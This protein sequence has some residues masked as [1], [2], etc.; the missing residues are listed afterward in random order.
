MVFPWLA[1][2]LKFIHKGSGV[3]RLTLRPQIHIPTHAASVL[4]LVARVKGLLV[5]LGCRLFVAKLLPA[6]PDLRVAGGG[7]RCL[8]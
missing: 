1:V 3:H 8:S 4:P 2:T 6:N 7:M 5:L